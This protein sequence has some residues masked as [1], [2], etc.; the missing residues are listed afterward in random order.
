MNGNDFLDKMGLVDP[1]FIQEA[2]DAYVNVS[3]RTVKPLRR[4]AFAACLVLLIGSVSVLAATGAGT[5]VLQWFSV[6]GPNGG[7]EAG[8]LLAADVE[9]FKE[10]ALKGEIR[11]VPALIREQY[12]A[13]EW[14]MSWHPGTWVKAFDERSK[15]CE[16]V[17]LN[18]LRQ[19]AW[20][21]EGE[22]ELTVYGDEDGRLQ[23]VTIQTPYTYGDLRL[24]FFTD[25]YTQHYE[26]DVTTGSF[27]TESVEFSESYETTANGTRIHVI[28]ST[29]LRSGYLCTEGYLVKDGILYHLHIAH[30]EQ[31]KDTARQL[32]HEWAE[33]F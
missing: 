16:Y 31:D 12:A 17:G 13:Y 21:P 14:Y 18:A 33:L 23:S 10:D 2:D 8:Y 6:G 5:K 24:S 20:L 25:I 30:L 32:V 9:I 22:T 19:I 15:A 26:G 3:K 1:A 27:T 29:A 4:L 28:E 7:E 11:E